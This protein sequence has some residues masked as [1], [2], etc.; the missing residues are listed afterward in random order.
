MAKHTAELDELDIP[1]LVDRLAE[2]K[3]EAFNLR[4]QHATGQL[5]N[6]ARLQRGAPTDR[7]HQHH[8]AP[9]RDRRGRSRT[10]GETPSR[11][12]LTA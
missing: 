10:D 8:A 6:T 3:D 7:P 9:A 5:D 2:T 11:R 1:A 4:F 12:Q